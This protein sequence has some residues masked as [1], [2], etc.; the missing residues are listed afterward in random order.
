MLATVLASGY[1]FRVLFRV[2]KL[3]SRF[4][5]TSSLCFSASS[6]AR[7]CLYLKLEA[8]VC[9]FVYKFVFVFLFVFVILYVLVCL[10]VLE[11]KRLACLFLYLSMSLSSYLS[12]HWSACLY[13]KYGSWL[14]SNLAPKGLI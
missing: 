12:L 13:L 9:V 8:G 1:F 4:N 11:V 10:P 5:S 2:W 6:S 14:A 7:A 3:F